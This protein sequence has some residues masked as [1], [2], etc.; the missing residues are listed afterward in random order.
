MTTQ[1]DG[2]LGLKVESFFGTGVTPDY[3]PEANSVA[4]SAEPTWAQ[5]N[6]MRVGQRI[7]YGD[8]RVLVKKSVGG[9]FELDLFS[10]GNGKLIQ[11]ALGGAGTSTL[12]AGSA[13]QQLFTPTTTDYLSSYT[14]Q[15]GIP[16]L[17]GGAV[18]PHTFVGMLCSGFELTGGNADVGKIKFN[19]VGKDL[20]TG[21]ALATASYVS[22]VEELSFVGGTV[23]LGGTMTVPTTTALSSG[24]T[25]T[26]NVVDI[27]LTYDNG[28]DT[29]GFNFGGGGLLSRKP[30]LGR[31]MISGSM[32]VEYTDNT[33]RDAWL[34]GTSLPLSIKY[35]SPTVISG[36]SYPTVEFDMPAIKLNSEIP[37]VTASGDVITTSID[38]EV[39][40]DRV[41]AHPFYVAIVTAETTI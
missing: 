7:N 10:K 36:S 23:G 15:V 28:L 22:G 6:G 12:I 34:A 19:W 14:I 38:F 13:Y 8:R 20:V 21:T 41:A 33:L 16:P 37:E 26:V 29:G 31:R 2:Q 30:A 25:A 39:V 27:N 1:L 18:L 3:F 11:A 24:T 9:S 35:A 40:D 17:G 5:G 32:T 4:L